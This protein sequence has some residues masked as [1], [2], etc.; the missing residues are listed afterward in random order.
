MNNLKVV[1]RRVYTNLIILCKFGTMLL[2]VCLIALFNLY[3]NPRIVTQD[4]NNVEFVQSF[5]P[6]VQPLQKDDLKQMN[7]LAMNLYHEARGEGA[8]GLMLVGWV[9]KNRVES[10]KF[11]NT[12]CDVVY[13][14]KG[15][16]AQFSWTND[17]LSDYPQD[18]EQWVHSLNY[19]YSVMFRSS[20]DI[21]EGSLFYHKN[22]GITKFSDA[23]YK[24]IIKTVTIG[25]HVAF[26]LK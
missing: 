8:Y 14:S 17:K 2:L 11:P 7:C 4:V 23:H 21:T 22:D 15:K 18:Q 5:V 6:V 19:A 12:Y 3:N 10:P 25:Q 9:T 13:Q 1:D 26:K 20:E 16:V 24:N